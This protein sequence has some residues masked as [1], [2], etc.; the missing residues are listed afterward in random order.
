M[1]VPIAA[2]SAPRIV[3]LVDCEGDHAKVRPKE[4]V[5]ACGDG[6][7]LFDKAVW[8]HWGNRTAL[9]SAILIENDCTPNCADGTFHSEPAKI[10]VSIVQKRHDRY[11]YRHIIG[12]AGL[13]VAVSCTPSREPLEV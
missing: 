3:Y 8:K 2:V 5:L 7:I 12:D 6:G 10:T 13:V 9:A 11:E 1:S 4:V